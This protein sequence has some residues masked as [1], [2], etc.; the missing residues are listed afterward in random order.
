MIDADRKR[1]YVDN[2]YSGPRWKKQVAKMPDDQITAIYLGHLKDGSV[3]DH[4]EE[5]PEV[6]TPLRIVEPEQQPLI[7]RNPHENED[8]FPIY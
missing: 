1:Q 2:L 7:P 8:D 6:E 5:G 4:V 3:P